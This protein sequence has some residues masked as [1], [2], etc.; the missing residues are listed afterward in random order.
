M[1]IQSKASRVLFFRSLQL[2]LSLIVVTAITQIAESQEVRMDLDTTAVRILLG[3]TDKEPIRW[4]SPYA[5]PVFS[6][7]VPV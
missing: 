5:I 1:V 7:P 3:V 6:P 2:C 4:A